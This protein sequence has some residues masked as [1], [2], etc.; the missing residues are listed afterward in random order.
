[1]ENVDA[2][3]EAG[4]KSLH[5]LN[6]SVRKGEVVGIAGVSGNGQAALVEI[7]AGQRDHTGRIAIAG[8]PYR[9]DRAQMRRHGI[10]L[11]P[12]EPLRNACVGKMSVAEN[13]AFRNFDCPP[14][15]R[16]SWLK[17]GAIRQQAREVAARYQVSAASLDM[18][19]RAL[20]GGNIQRAVLGR[21]LSG[22][23]EL[24]ICANATFG[25]DFSAAADIHRQIMTARN[26]GAAVLLVSED[27][28]ELLELS[29]RI[30][31]MQGG[32]IGYECARQD[33]DRAVIGRHMAGHH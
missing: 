1:L 31:V 15:S 13:I 5:A 28:D 22:A 21:E 25:L 6:L 23:V 18:P 8:E 19:I 26:R 30:L 3:D 16:G 4:A 9:A 2:F 29:D 33:A 14:V 27:L 11:L 17:Y 10:A 24:L 7:L 20:S 12:E 32:R